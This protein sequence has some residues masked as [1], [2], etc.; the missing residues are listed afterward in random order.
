[1]LIYGTTTIFPVMHTF[2]MAA[3]VVIVAVATAATA[4]AV[5]GLR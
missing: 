5:K 1:M 2:Q 3:G 4:A